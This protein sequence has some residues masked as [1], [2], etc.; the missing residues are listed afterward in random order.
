M[1]SFDDM[2]SF[3]GTISFFCTASWNTAGRQV[4]LPYCG[5]CKARASSSAARMFRRS[6]VVPCLGMTPAREASMRAFVHAAML[7][8]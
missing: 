2:K 1:L 4:G 6:W 5:C 8:W 3:K 7:A